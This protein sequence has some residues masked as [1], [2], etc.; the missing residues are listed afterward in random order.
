MTTSRYVK[1]GGTVSEPAYHLDVSGDVNITGEFRKNGAI[2]TG[3]R[4]SVSTSPNIFY[5]DGNVAIGSTTSQ[6]E[7][8]HITGNMRATGNLIVAR[9]GIGVSSLTTGVA[10]G[11]TLELGLGTGSFGTPTAMRYW[12]FANNPTTES[13]NLGGITLKVNGSVWLNKYIDKIE[14]GNVNVYGF[15]SQQI[16]QVIP[17]AISIQ[18]SYI[19]NIM[20]L[21]YYDND[22]ITL[23]SQPTKVII[24]L[25][26]KIKCYDKDNNEINIEVEEVIDDLTFR[27]K[28]LEYTD[29][30]IF[31]SGTEVYDF[32]TLDKS[33]IY[34]LNVCATQELHRRIQSQDERIKELETKLEKLIN[35]I[36]Q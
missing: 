24:K 15:I 17:E 22:I 30:K 26:D 23:P 32:H 11:Y 21:A 25:N 36:Y 1:I 13:F 3:S 14:R 18:K 29:S 4:W 9:A 19:P 33:Y 20:L 10:A 16:R 28:E 6:T 7:K 34:T 12:D 35:Y 2:I 5:N 27:I 31:V 8:L